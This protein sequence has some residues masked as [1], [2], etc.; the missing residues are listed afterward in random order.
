MFWHPD[1]PRL[2]DG[3]VTKQTFCIAPAQIR[4]STVVLFQL[5]A[6]A[7]KITVVNYRE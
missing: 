7:V 5:W 1:F 6:L 2:N 4:S 3:V